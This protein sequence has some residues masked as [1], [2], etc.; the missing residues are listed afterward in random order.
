MKYVELKFCALLLLAL[1]QR[2][3]VCAQESV[4]VSGGSV[5]GT[6]GIVSYSVGQVF[7]TT[8]TSVS[9]GSVSHGMQ[10][11]YQISV[12]T[13]IVVSNDIELTIATFPNPTT[14]LLTL[15][16]ENYN[17]RNL[18]YQLLDINGMVLETRNLDGNQTIINMSQLVSA[19]YFV[20]V[21]E[22]NNEIK[23]FKIIK[24]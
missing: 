22:N 1:S 5:S 13:E 18:I 10:M 8:I 3:N 12:E 11:R 19:L 20:K 4:N 23:T 14:D 16:V 2:G 21:I 24:N 7:Y 6:G 15:Q 17:N 9:N